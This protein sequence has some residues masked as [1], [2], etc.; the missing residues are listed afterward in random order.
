MANSKPDRPV[1]S[2][3]QSARTPQQQA[4]RD[5]AY[6][7][8]RAAFAAGKPKRR[9]WD[10]VLSVI[11]LLGLGLVCLAMTYLGAILAVFP[12]QCESQNIS[13]DYDRINWGVAVALLVPTVVTLIVVGTTIIRYLVGRVVFWIPIVGI[14]LCII[15]GVIGSQLVTSAIPGSGLY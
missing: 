14:V 1:P 6:G 5:E 3:R 15:A 11:L 2:S 13:C 12:A 10:L 7:S 8:V 4:L 9:R